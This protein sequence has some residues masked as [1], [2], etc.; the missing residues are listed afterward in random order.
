MGFAAPTKAKAQSVDGY[1]VAVGPINTTAITTKLITVWKEW[2]GP[3]EALLS[4]TA[5]GGA[6]NTYI[7]DATIVDIDGARKGRFHYCISPITDTGT[8]WNV[9]SVASA[10][11]PSLFVKCYPATAI[12]TFEDSSHYSSYP[13]TVTSAQP[14]SKTAAGDGRLFDAAYIM[15]G[16]GNTIGGPAIAT[17]GWAAFDGFSTETDGLMGGTSYK[18]QS[19]AGAENP[20]CTWSSLQFAGA[21][22]L[23]FASGGGGGG[24]PAPVVSSITPSSAIPNASVDIILDNVQIAGT[25]LVAGSPIDATVTF[26]NANVT[27]EGSPSLSSTLITLDVRI[28]ANA[29]TDVGTVIVT[30]TGGTSSKPF[31]LVTGTGGGGGITDKDMRGGFVN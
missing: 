15:G 2:Y 28:A 3:N 12:P 5:G 27:V 26:S 23:V 13:S 29:P 6:G 19:I 10:S 16:A 22:M 21:A 25:D 20:Q 30:T 31:S 7:A 1:N 18:I 9:E 11:Y 24:G 8:T 17:S 4:D 14:G